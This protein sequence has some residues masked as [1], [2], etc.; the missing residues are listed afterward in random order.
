[1]ESLKLCVKIGF[2]R[3]D[4]RELQHTSPTLKSMKTLYK[5]V[6]FGG[7]FNKEEIEK[8]KNL[9]GT[10]RVLVVLALLFS[11]VNIPLLLLLVSPIC[12]S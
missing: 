7:K 10:L 11:K 4:N 1:M 12:L 5:R 8:L 3:V 2:S 6:N 9:L